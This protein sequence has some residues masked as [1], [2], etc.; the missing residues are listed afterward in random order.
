[1]Y[2]ALVSGH[3]GGAGLDVHADEP[4]APRDRF[5]RL[6]VWMRDLLGGLDHEEGFGQ[7][8]WV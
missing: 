1:L 5:T 4:R 2:E 7:D 3:L 6:T 8:A